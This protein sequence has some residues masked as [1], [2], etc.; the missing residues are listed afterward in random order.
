[1][2]VVPIILPN[3][4]VLYRPFHGDFSAATFLCSCVGGFKCET[5]FVI[6]SSSDYRYFYWC[7]WKAIYLNCGI[8]RASQLTSIGI[9]HGFSCIHAEGRGFQHLQRDLAYVNALE[10]HVRSLLLHTNRIHLLHFGLFYA[11]FCFTFSPMPRE[12]NF[13]W[14]CSF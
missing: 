6:V 14:L 8:P 4:F 5:C 1:M 11:L 13:H 2:W 10:N 12:R 3:R 7:L 9:K